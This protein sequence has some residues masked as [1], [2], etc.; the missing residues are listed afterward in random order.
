MKFLILL[1]L[2]FLGCTNKTSKKVV[3]ADRDKYG[4]IPS[5]GYS[6]CAKKKQCV[7]SW[8]LAKKEGFVNNKKSFDSFCSE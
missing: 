7:R 4:C 3:G 6:W 5:A 2:F 1:P 8:E